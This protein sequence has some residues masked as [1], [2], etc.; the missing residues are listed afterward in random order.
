LTWNFIALPAGPDADTALHLACLY[1]NKPCVETL[2]AAGCQLDVINSLDGTS[3]L[4]DAAA[5]GYLGIAQLL[6]DKAGA[7]LVML[8]V[9]AAAIGIAAGAMMMLPCSA[10]CSM[11]LSLTV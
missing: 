10:L 8:Q 5:G 6:V 11:G 3:P 1:G 7:G 4:H 9:R 2:I